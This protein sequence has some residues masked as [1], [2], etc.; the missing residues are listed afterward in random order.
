M[1]DEIQFADEDAR[2]AAAAIK[3]LR[4]KRDSL[5]KSIAEI[6]KVIGG[7]KAWDGFNINSIAALV[8]KYLPKIKAAGLIGT[9]VGIPFLPQ[10]GGL[11]GK[12]F[13]G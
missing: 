8:K 10:L 13:G 2:K 12:L 11:V 3:R 9:G 7:A 4:E 5:V 6:D 1:A